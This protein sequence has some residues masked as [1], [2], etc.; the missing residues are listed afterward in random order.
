MV[1]LDKLNKHPFVKKSLLK[2]DNL[3]EI[4][5]I[6]IDHF[7]K[8]INSNPIE[9]KRTKLAYNNY[10]DFFDL[11]DTVSRVTGIPTLYDDFSHLTLK[12]KESY[13]IRNNINYTK[14]EFNHLIIESKNYKTTQMLGSKHWCIQNNEE[15]WNNYNQERVHLL[16]ATDDNFYGLSYSSNYFD[17]Y[18]IDNN[19][20]S[21]GSIIECIP[22]EYNISMYTQ[23]CKRQKRTH[24]ENLITDFMIHFKVNSSWIFDLFL[25]ML[26]YELIQYTGQI[27]GL[28][29]LL[30][31]GV[32]VWSSTTLFIKLIEISNVFPFLFSSDNS[33]FPSFLQSLFSG[34]KLGCQKQLI[35]ILITLVFSAPLIQIPFTLMGKDNIV[36]SFIYNISNTKELVLNGDIK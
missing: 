11:Y 22:K 2:M 31:S 23:S 14:N 30:L 33:S 27:K 28:S 24:S 8:I 34:F 9:L 25:L 15:D 5:S 6:Y 7:C 10:Y 4:D 21:I 35:L 36:K 13:L 20:V 1:N 19:P 12:D 32:L 3:E 17:C 18:N 16:L 26:T 29:A